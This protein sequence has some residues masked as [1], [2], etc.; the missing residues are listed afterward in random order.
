MLSRKN[1]VFSILSLGLGIF[2]IWLILRF[3]N[4]ELAEV[5]AKLYDLNPWYTA[6]AI[7][8]LLI[9]TWFTAYK[10]NLVTH[11]V[12]PDREQPFRFYLFYT[13]LGSLTMQFMPQYIGMVAV[14]NLALRVHKVSSLSKGFLSVIY[15]QFFNFLI[16]FLLF[17]AS[18]LFVLGHISLGIAVFATSTIIIASHFIIKRWYRYLMGLLIKSYISF[19]NSRKKSQATHSNIAFKNSD[20]LDRKFTLNQYWLSVIRYVFWLI[21]GVVIVYAGGLKIGLW[22]VVF[23]TPIVQLAMLVSFTPANL[24]LMELSWVGLL[25]LFNVSNTDAVQFA[26]LQRFLYVVA[27]AL[28]LVGFLFVW[29]IERFFASKPVKDSQK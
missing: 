18:I 3:T 11:Q 26:L 1:V 19:K 14:Q 24:G 25:A 7:L 28:A 15:D 5:I 12:T 2:L 21:R 13:T 29:T 27:T 20:I 10:W 8:T 17:P 6:L 16:P 4:V 9:H 23:T 22:A